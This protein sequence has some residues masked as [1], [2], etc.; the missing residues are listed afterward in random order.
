MDVAVDNPSNPYF[1]KVCFVC[2]EK[3]K[4]NTLLAT[5]Y[6]GISDVTKEYPLTEIP[7]SEDESE[8]PILFDF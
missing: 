4:D 1:L 7:F 8:R 3:S 5:H 6:G 2:R